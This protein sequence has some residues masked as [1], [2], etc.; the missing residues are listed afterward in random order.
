MTRSRSGVH[1]ALASNT[2][3]RQVLKFRCLPELVSILPKP[4]P[5]VLG[6]PDWFK[7]MP[8][9]AFNPIA[10][11]NSQTVKRCPPFIDAMTYG[12]LIPLICDLKVDNGAFSWEFDLPQSGAAGAVRAPIGFHDPSQVA[13]TPLFDED[14]FVIKF[15]NL[16]TIEAPPGYSVLITH[17]VNRSDLPFTTLTGLIDCDLYRD[18]WVH[19]PAHWNDAGFTG[20]LPK[21]TPVAQCIPVKRESWTS[22]IGPMSD[23][24]ARRVEDMSQAIVRDQGIYRRQFR[25]PKR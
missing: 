17:P 6:L 23:D 9:T 21:G 5:A 20:V 2:E 13:D 14:R 22:E 1:Q 12:F 25:A 4:V 18:N 3:T 15:H 11:E 10:Q 19:F 24:D 16:W 7:T 8:Q